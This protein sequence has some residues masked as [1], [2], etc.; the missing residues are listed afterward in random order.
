MFSFNNPKFRWNL[1]SLHVFFGDN[2]PS[3]LSVA[4]NQWIHAA[5]TFDL[6]T[7]AMLIYQ[8]GVLGGSCISGQPAVCLRIAFKTKVEKN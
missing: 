7:H 4:L 6:T 5:F 1:P 2:C 8:D 3:N